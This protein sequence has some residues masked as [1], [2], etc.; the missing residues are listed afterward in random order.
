M[1]RD[2][3]EQLNEMGPEYRAVVDRLV[4]AYRPFDAA[5]QA[6][7]RSRLGRI[8][9]WSAAYLL[10]ASLLVFLGLSLVFRPAPTQSRVYTVRATDAAREYVL[11]HVRNDE[12]VKELIRT[13]NADGSWKNDFL[14]RQNAEALKSATDEA[15]R[16]AY[17]KALRN[18]R[19]RGLL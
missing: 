10:A 19:S 15:A 2:L 12:A 1:N 17:K 5:A 4:G 6:S 13:Q 7:P 16:I 9:G 3:E 18:L 14:T 8:V 11:A